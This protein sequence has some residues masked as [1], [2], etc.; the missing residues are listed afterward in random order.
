MMGHDFLITPGTVI[1]VSFGNDEFT[2]RCEVLSRNR[3]TKYCNSIE[4]RVR[5][6]LDKRE[7]TALL[8]N[9]AWVARDAH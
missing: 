1:G 4:V 2:R 7:F 8:V 5:R 6:F 3:Q 9:N